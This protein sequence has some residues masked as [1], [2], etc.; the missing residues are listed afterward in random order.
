[1]NQTE[2]KKRQVELGTYILEM[3]CLLVMGNF[4]GDNGI[5]YFA[6][7]FE[8]FLFFQ[9]LLTYKLA[10]TL[11]RLIRNRTIKGQYKNARKFKKNLMLTGMIT[12]LS[13]SVLLFV[14]AEALGEKAFGLTYSVAIIR[15]LAPVI[16][17]RTII[18]I[19]LG[20]FQGDGTE[21]P[22]V[23]TYVMRQVCTLLLAVLFVRVLSGYGNKVSALLRQ[24]DFTAMYGGMGLALAI[25]ISELLVFLFLIFVYQGSRRRTR[26]SSGDGMRVTDTFGSQL[27]A[28]SINLFPLVFVALLNHLPMWTG[29]LFFRKS[30]EN[31]EAFSCYGV[32]YG[33]FIPIMVILALPAVV[34]LLGNCYKIWDAQR[35]D[36]QRNARTVFAGGFH[37]CMVYGFFFSIFT[38]IVAPQLADLAGGTSVELTK[39]MLQ[40]GCAMILFGVAGYYF[41]ESL[42]LLNRR[43]QV[44][45]IAAA[46]GIVYI[47]TL[48]ILLNQGVGIVSL[49]FAGLASEIVFASAT[50]VFLCR[51]LRTG[52]DPIRQIAIPMGVICVAGIV[53]WLVNKGL[54]P[55]LGG[56]ISIVLCLVIGVLISLVPLVFLRNFREQELNFIPGGRFLRT[57][58]QL[59]RIY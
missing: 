56:G 1:M 57:L 59:L 9:L 48:S 31:L 52:V 55:H 42:L 45:G 21:L 35:K 33:K 16:F 53:I 10:D 49:V 40:S 11:G 58:G 4:L 18:S 22:A 39:Q 41:S 38:G 23:I 25:L 17:F 13:G 30:V 19:L 36:E 12:G 26:K 29:I 2:L 54:A 14:L 27:R 6:V 7:A 46:K 37:F 8:C 47:L 34:A 15:I 24:D 32:F 20:Y 44:A 43:F 51:M 5:A 28:V 3:I 50:C